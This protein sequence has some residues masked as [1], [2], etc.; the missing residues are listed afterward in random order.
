M[1][2][3]LGCRGNGA[4]R[5]GFAKP[6][7]LSP[8]RKRMRMSLAIFFRE[9]P[10]LGR[11][12]LL[13]QTRGDFPRRFSRKLSCS[14]QLPRADFSVRW[15]DQHRPRCASPHARQCCHRDVFESSESVCGSDNQIHILFF[16]DR[17][18]FL[19]RRA[20]RD[21]SLV[22]HAAEAGLAHELRHLPLS[23]LARAFCNSKRSYMA[24]P[25]A[26]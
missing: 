20:D 3:P 15:H 22:F 7:G 1:P 13:C 4:R 8:F 17:A 26:V 23:F 24:K 9:L 14:R 21:C 10:G 25:S 16:R 19:N 12:L 11:F 2:C 5:M 6:V 18:N